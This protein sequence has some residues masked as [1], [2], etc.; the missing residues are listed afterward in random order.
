[1][2]GLAK[3]TAIEAKVLFLRDPVVLLVALAVPIGIL[4]VFVVLAGFSIG[5]AYVPAAAAL[6]W[7]TIALADK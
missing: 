4:L 2:R 7:A 1:M 6:I 3:L 5:P